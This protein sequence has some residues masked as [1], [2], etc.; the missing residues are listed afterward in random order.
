[1]KIV[2]F[3]ENFFFFTKKFLP[4]LILQVFLEIFLPQPT[5]MFLIDLHQPICSFANKAC[6]LAIKR[7]LKIFLEIIKGI[8]RLQQN[9]L[10]KLCFSQRK[11]N[12]RVFFTKIKDHNFVFEYYIFLNN[13]EGQRFTSLF[14]QIL[15]VATK[16][17]SKTDFFVG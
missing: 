6:E 5:A 17:E 10:V 9:A 11:S 12:N 2:Y 8:E 16:Q 13:L 7:D 15:Q 14:S 4:I 1:M 3:Y